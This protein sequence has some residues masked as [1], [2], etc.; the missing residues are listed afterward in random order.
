MA[1]D[2][3][4]LL[5]A[6]PVVITSA[7]PRAGAIATAIE[8]LVSSEL[9]RAQA[10]DP[11]ATMESLIDQALADLQKSDANFDEGI[12]KANEWLKKGHDGE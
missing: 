9:A 8:A 7:D 4:A 10:V 12:R 5:K 1:F 6:M 2:W 3:K 11:N